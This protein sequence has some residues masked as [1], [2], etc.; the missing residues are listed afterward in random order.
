MD[1]TAISSPTWTSAMTRISPDA[2][3][4]VSEPAKHEEGE[5]EEEEEE[6]GGPAGLNAGDKVL[7]VDVTVV[8]DT[9]TGRVRSPSRSPRVHPKPIFESFLLGGTWEINTKGVLQVD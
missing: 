8:P 6:V 2:S 3:A 4:T 9:L 7:D 5:E 1:A